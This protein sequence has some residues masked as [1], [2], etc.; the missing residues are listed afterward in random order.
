MFGIG[1]LRWKQVALGAGA[2]V[3]GPSLARP[4]LVMATRAGLGIAQGATTVWNQAVAESGR[5]KAEALA[6]KSEPSSSEILNELR[7]LRQDVAD[8]KSKTGLDKKN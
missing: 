7:A 4:V 2:V 8:I 1:A 5:V 3:F 6:K